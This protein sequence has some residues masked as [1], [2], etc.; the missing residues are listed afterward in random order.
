MLNGIQETPAELS[1]AADR[2]DDVGQLL[3][4]ALKST[5]WSDMKHEGAPSD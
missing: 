5:S 1:R 2:I 3:G 4:V